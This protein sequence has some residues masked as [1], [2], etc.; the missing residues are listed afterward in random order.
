MTNCA[1]TLLDN[2]EVVLYVDT[3][4]SDRQFFMRML[5]HLAQV[6][7][8]DIETGNITKAEKIKIEEAM[9]YLKSKKLSCDCY[10]G[11][12]Y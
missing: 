10:P 2:D 4:I 5:A 1:K 6:R 8:R 11:I 9:K 7:Y 3:E 12:R